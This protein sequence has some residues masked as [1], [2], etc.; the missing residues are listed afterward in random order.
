[1]LKYHAQMNVDRRGF[2]LIELL[3]TIA[4]I[5]ILAAI[6]LPV[7]A[8]ARAKARQTKCMSNLRQLGI[9]MM[10]YVD[11]W[12]ET[13]PY[14]VKPR[15]PAAPGASP[16]YDGTNKWDASPIV[17]V[18]S[19]YSTSIKLPFC[20]DR[21]TKLDDIGPLTNYEFNGFIALNDSPSAP[22]NG[23]VRLG[24][25]INP[26]QVLIF[27]DY[28]NTTKYHAGFRNFALADGSA[29]AYPARQQ[30]AAACHAK[31]WY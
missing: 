12:D 20:P 17:G 25:I 9:A 4:I 7:F 10:M 6:L 31:W 16:A 27:E 2:S 18:I 21:P 13:F 3:V 5:S 29:R 8:S 15:T 11:D 22:H 28:G 1:M 23:P 26:T 24:D 19:P 14:D 30:A